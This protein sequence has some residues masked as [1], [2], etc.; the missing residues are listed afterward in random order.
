M[1]A[2]PLTPKQRRFVS[3]YL[4][5]SNATQAAIRCG[6][7]KKAA[8]QT[9]AKLVSIPAI[10]SAIET[11]TQKAVEKAELTAERI[12]EE[13]RRIAL[14]DPRKTFDD[15]G[16]LKP[17]KEWGDDEAASVAGYEVVKRNMTAGDGVT[18]TVARVRHA[19]KLKA[20]DLAA[21]HFGLLVEKQQHFGEIVV[22]WGGEET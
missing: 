16:N 9:G 22:K 20:L 2:K 21:R 1:S 12:L 3:E 15:A 18:D 17:I 7:A 5:D 11:G 19:D 8:R 13:I 4:V 6:Y 10:R 14:Y